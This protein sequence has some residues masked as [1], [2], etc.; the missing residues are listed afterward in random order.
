VA[1]FAMVKI[2]EKLVSMKGPKAEE[3]KELDEKDVLIEIRDL[4]A[5]QNRQA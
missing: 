5:Q 4:L 1:I 3:A 2:Y